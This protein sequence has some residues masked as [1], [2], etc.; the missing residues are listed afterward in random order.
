MQKSSI[1][2]GKGCP[3]ATKEQLKDVIGITS[4][5]LSEKYLGLPTVV[6][7]SKEG[8]FQYLPDRSWSKVRGWKG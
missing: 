4:E 7:R 1:Y 3:D 5:A 2:F 6:G 8:A